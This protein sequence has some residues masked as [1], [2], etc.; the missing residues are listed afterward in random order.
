MPC[1]HPAL[2]PDRALLT[3]PKHLYGLS[4]KRVYRWSLKPYSGH[5][6][7]SNNIMLHH[8]G[9]YIA[10]ARDVVWA[11]GSTGNTT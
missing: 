1:Q 4:Y 3:I 7:I 11:L 2:K 6:S 10:I 8:N 9:P 5:V